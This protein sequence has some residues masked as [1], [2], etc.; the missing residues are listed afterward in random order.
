MVTKCIQHINM[1]NTI[2]YLLS[3]LF[4][5]RST[6]R[7]V[8]VRRESFVDDPSPDEQLNYGRSRSQYGNLIIHRNKSRM[9]KNPYDCDEEYKEEPSYYSE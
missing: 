5:K 8:H 3:K 6:S 4:G 9:V 1:Y 2:L 7:T